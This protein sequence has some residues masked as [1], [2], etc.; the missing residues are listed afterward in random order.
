MKSLGEVRLLFLQLQLEYSSF[1][2]S[3]ETWNISIRV[4]D[5]AV[6]SFCKGACFYR[7][8]S[9]TLTILSMYMT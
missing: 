8:E 5:Y 1:A 6:I 4:G 7:Q 2:G 9:W 3:H